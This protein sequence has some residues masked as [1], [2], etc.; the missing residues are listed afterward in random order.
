[1]KR[2]LYHVNNA[3]LLPGR[4]RGIRERRFS[5]EFEMPLARGTMLRKT[6]G[7]A[8]FKRFSG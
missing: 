7:G 1:M 4:R 5:R 2:G 8:E 6:S 3:L